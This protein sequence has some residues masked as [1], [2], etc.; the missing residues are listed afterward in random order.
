MHVWPEAESCW[1][2]EGTHIIILKKNWSTE[3]IPHIMK[4][5]FADSR[6]LPAETKARSRHGGA[7][8]LLRHGGVQK[9]A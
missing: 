3:G 8:P 9:P 2:T 4:N 7:T 5:L 1:S 6:Q